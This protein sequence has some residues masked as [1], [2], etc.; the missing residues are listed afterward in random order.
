M[1][2]SVLFNGELGPFFATWQVYWSFNPKGGLNGQKEDFSVANNVKYGSW[3]VHPYL[4]N[5]IVS[6]QL[7]KEVTL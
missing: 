6:T 2:A 4:S 5:Y 1:E 7:I 3:L